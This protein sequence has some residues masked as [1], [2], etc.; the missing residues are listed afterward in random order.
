[1]ATDIALTMLRMHA[2]FGHSNVQHLGFLVRDA[3]CAARL[4]DGK[5]R[6]VARVD[7]S[8]S[9]SCVCISGCDFENG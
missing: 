2:R 6:T 3:N 5:R 7:P 1:M 4:T 9:T 8:K